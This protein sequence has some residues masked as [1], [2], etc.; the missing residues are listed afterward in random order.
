M[1]FRNRNIAPDQKLIDALKQMDAYDIKL[2]IVIEGKHFAG[3]LSAGDIQRAIINDVSLT[4]PINKILRKNIR[5]G[6]P[7]DSFETI[8][9]MM[10][11]F[12]MELCPVVNE[13]NEIEEIYFWE[14]VIGS[15]K[16]APNGRFDLPVI[17]MAGG[18]GTRMKPLTNVLPKPLI[19][20]GEKTMLEEIIDRFT[21]HGCKRFYLSVNYKADLIEYY[22]RERRLE[23][24]WEC[25]RETVPMGT[26]GSLSL[27]KDKIST[28]FFIN[29]CDILIEQDYSEMLT[30]HRESR[31]EITMVAALKS[32]TIPYGI[33]ESGAS[34]QLQQL[35]E[36]P[37]L[38]FKINSG[39][40]ILEPHLLEE[41]P[42]NELFHI[43]DLILKV[44]ER[45]GRVGVFPVSEK[46]WKD[47][48]EWHE[49][50]EMI[51]VG[52]KG[53]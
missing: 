5:V 40:Y 52:R 7:T 27:L 39:M 47:I 25:F 11:Q 28:T 9:K 44:K 2:L 46:S 48:G 8:K 4:E 35:K 18:F 49:Y 10:F 6:N 32:Y 21:K 17:V 26:A 41:I 22:L 53:K 12:R 36:K 20:I 45:S 38:T 1:D 15:E 42:E 23:V 30:Y 31:N 34:G 51:K 24:E 14:D 33:V 50:L 16:E 43:T 3:L 19:P 37:D 29:N 13:E